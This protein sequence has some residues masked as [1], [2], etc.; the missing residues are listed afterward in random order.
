VIHALL[1]L[2]PRP[3]TDTTKPDPATESAKSEPGP[4]TES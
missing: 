1:G 4:V 3:T 2:R